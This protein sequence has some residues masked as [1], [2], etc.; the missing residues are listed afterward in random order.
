[1]LKWYLLQR[2]HFTF[3]TINR[4]VWVVFFGWEGDEAGSV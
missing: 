1:M 2:N 4:L 3:L